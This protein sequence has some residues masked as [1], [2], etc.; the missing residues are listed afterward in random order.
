MHVSIF[1][2]HDRYFYSI[3][4]FSLTHL[5]KWWPFPVLD[6][7]L[8][9]ISWC[10]HSCLSNSQPEDVGRHT[11]ADAHQ[12]A[13][14]ILLQY[15]RHSR[16][17]GFHVAI[18]RV[19]QVLDHISPPLTHSLHA[20]AT[21]LLHPNHLLSTGLCLVHSDLNVWL[22]FLAIAAIHTGCSYTP[23]H[24]Y[25]CDSRCD[26]RPKYFLFYTCT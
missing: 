4:C 21:V 10:L 5:E 14:N 26:L 24:C 15:W 13:A 18:T 12:K 25:H 23:S 2:A 22:F 6:S 9:R 11:S 20:V 16:K 3:S 17:P 1:L 19:V 7:S 8:L